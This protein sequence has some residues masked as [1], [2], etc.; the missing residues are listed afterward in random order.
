[1]DEDIVPVCS[2][3]FRTARR[4]RRVEDL[5]RVPLVHSA[6]RPADWA[7][8]FANAKLPAANAFQGSIFENFAMISKA[9]VSGLG[10]ALLPTFFVEEEIRNRSL[11]A[12]A[13]PQRSKSAYHLVIP[14]TKVGTPH[15]EAFVKW[16]DEK[17]KRPQEGR[18]RSS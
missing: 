12:L 2:P 1:M 18:R 16:I 14:E 7:G 11:I 8:W 5:I 13:P 9:A 6:T 3:A 4:I 15:V 10:V 17:T